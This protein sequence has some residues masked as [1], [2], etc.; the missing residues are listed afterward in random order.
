M[1]IERFGIG[2]RGGPEVIPR[3]VE[4]VVLV[5][6]EAKEA[7]ARMVEGVAVVLD[8]T[9]RLDEG[10]AGLLDAGSYEL[11]S[12]LLFLVEGLVSVCIV[13][14]GADGGRCAMESG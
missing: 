6:H 5:L 14:D 4:G 12:R 2:N 1:N 10:R 8:E 3:I 9:D 13:G 11:S 7:L